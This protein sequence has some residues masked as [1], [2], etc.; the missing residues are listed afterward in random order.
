MYY[1]YVS[2]SANVYIRCV[3]VYMYTQRRTHGGG[4]ARPR[5]WAGARIGASSAG[6]KKRRAPG[7][8]SPVPTT[9]RAN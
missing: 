4:C 5:P 9:T 6:W 7:H 2:I 8:P 3:Y 1:V